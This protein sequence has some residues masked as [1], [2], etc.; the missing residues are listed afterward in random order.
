MTSDEGRERDRGKNR[1]TDIQA[2]EKDTGSPTNRQEKQT[3]G[4]K[5]TER[6]T[7]GE[8]EIERQTEGEKETDK[9]RG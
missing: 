7:E 4:E 6:Q 8:T 9:G 3:A 5:E 1:E 2:E